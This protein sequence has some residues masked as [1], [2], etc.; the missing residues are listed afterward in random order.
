L[1]FI[2]RQITKLLSL[3]DGVEKIK[4]VKNQ[5]HRVGIKEKGDEC[6]IVE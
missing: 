1:Q 2:G 5:K 3:P 6:D 4:M